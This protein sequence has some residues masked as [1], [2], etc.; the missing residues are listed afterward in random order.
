LRDTFLKPD[1]S[2]FKTS[3]RNRTLRFAQQ[4]YPNPGNLYIPGR[5]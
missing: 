1:F 4:D 3:S 5:G 2:S